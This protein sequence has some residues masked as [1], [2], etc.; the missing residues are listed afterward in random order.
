M[1][2]V[3]LKKENGMIY[4]KLLNFFYRGPKF[5]S[6]PLKPGIFKVE[7]DEIEHCYKLIF[8]YSN[9]TNNESDNIFYFATT[10][11]ANL[12]KEKIEDFLLKKDSIS[13]SYILKN[14]LY[15]L[16]IIALPIFII[17]LSTFNKNQERSLFLQLYQS[18]ANANT[19]IAKPD[20]NNEMLLKILKEK[21]NNKVQQAPP[22]TIPVEN[23]TE[24]V[25]TPEPVVEKE[26]KNKELTE[27]EKLMAE[28]LKK[29]KE[30]R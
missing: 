27:E 25:N 11:E 16:S 12:V 10:K 6:L 24:K 30:N 21:E 2:I 18:Q 9:T 17:M 8:K 13:L 1:K 19:Q 29:L 4:I 3:K 28:Q 22:L 15:V 5:I 7:K 14:A 26:I 20:S 23:K